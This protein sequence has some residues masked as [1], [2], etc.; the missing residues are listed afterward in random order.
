MALTEVISDFYTLA[1]LPK[2]KVGTS[3]KFAHTIIE[4]QTTA[5]ASGGSKRTGS[6]NAP[7]VSSV[8][9]NFYIL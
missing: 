3:M 8:T 7:Q 5:I 9:S 6:W 2:N 1:D 4:Q